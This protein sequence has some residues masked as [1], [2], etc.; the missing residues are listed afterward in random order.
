[1]FL[2]LNILSKPYQYFIFNLKYHFV[3]FTLKFITVLIYFIH[4]ACF[5]IALDEAHLTIVKLF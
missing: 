4:R 1:M 3:L 5:K 2:Y